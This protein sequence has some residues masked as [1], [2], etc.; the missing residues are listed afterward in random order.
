MGTKIMTRPIIKE[1]NATTGEIVEREMDDAEFAK[2]EAEAA[3]YE[4]TKSALEQK[5]IARAEILERLGLTA[6]EAAILL[7]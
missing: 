5:A 4:A 1:H 6:E 7:G 2:F 3:E